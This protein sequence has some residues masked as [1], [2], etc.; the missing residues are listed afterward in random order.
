MPT[1]S[2][3]LI[4]GASGLLGSALAA[5]LSSSHEIV[6]LVRK[7]MVGPGEV[8]WEP[9]KTLD[10]GLV[11]GCDA[12]IHLGGESIVGRWTAAKKARIRDS[13]IGG[14]TTLAEALTRTTIK[15][16]V[17]L[18]ASAI[19]Y[20]GDRGDEIL[21]EDS[22]SGTGFLAETSRAWEAATESASQS[23]IRVVNLRIGVVLAQQGGAL[24]KMLLPFKLGFG[25]RIGSGRQWWSWIHI[26]DIVGAVTHILRTDSLRGPVNLVA[27]NP[28]TNAEFTKT[29]AQVLHRP[30]FLPMPAFATRLA[31][32]EMA[33]AA[34]LASQRVEP[35]KLTASGYAF[36]FPELHDALRDLLGVSRQ[37]AG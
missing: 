28:A 29:L 18:S 30:A 3:V 34:L 16:R 22:P 31:L 5:S 26:A 23:G 7:P 24:D 33:D 11:S 20:Y 37:V 36:Q 4:S 6:R 15:P 13:R 19:G 9:G 1:P 32:G 35:A 2:R 21:R 10:P 14:T 25:G 12:V 8:P 27:P 17:L